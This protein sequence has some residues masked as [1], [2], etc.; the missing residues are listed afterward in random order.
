NPFN[1]STTINFQIPKSSEVRLVVY[2]VLGQKVRTLV[3]QHL[4]TGY[5]KVV[6]DGRNEQGE[7]VASGVYIYRFKAGDF[8]RDYKMILLR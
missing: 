6:W 2:N 1:P 5:Y 3:N 7:P 4:E 8:Q